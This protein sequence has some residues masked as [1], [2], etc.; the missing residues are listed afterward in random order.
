[1]TCWRAS[2]RSS[3]APFIPI[4]G[5]ALYRADFIRHLS[6]DPAWTKAQDWG[7]ALTVCLAGARFA[8]LSRSSMIYWHHAETRISSRGAPPLR[9]T[10]A[11]QQLLRMIEQ[12]LRI[13]N[14]LTDSRKRQLAQYYYRDCQILA[15]NDP[16]EWQRVWRHCKELHPGFQPLE[17]NR[18]M[19]LFTRLLGVHAGVRAYVQVKALL[20]SRHE[21]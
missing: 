1:M 2:H 11:R 10:Q 8:S 12:E 14:A 19:R 15:R 6:W 7:W 9:S 21:A 20:W 13:Q 18:I 5:G 16:K 4:I 3:G 17:P